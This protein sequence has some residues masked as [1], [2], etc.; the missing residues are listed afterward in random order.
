[1][2]GDCNFLISS[3]HLLEL[4]HGSM[5][6]RDG[7]TLTRPVEYTERR[8]IH[9]ADMDVESRTADPDARLVI[10]VNNSRRKHHGTYFQLLS[11]TPI[12]G[13]L[14][15]LTPFSRCF[16]LDVSVHVHTSDVRCRSRLT[17][18][19]GEIPHRDR[20][21]ELSVKGYYFPPPFRCGFAIR[22]H[23]IVGSEGS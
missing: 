15:S 12:A 5:G 2:L 8:T 3:K 16:R 1:M 20:H 11:T 4:A 7:R 19:P 6:D 23:F 9:R 13:C 21:S 17:L 18:H 14:H 10:V 22:G